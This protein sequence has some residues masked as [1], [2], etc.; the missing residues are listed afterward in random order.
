MGVPHT[1]GGQFRFYP[2]ELGIIVMS[3]DLKDVS[4]AFDAELC[5]GVLERAAASTTLKRAARLRQ[6]LF[7]VGAQ[8]LKEGRT[9]IHEQEIGRA[10]FGRG[11]RTTPARTILCG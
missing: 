2:V 10:V 8:S 7:Y 11:K 9:D 3:S 6:F 1:P 4:L 5:W